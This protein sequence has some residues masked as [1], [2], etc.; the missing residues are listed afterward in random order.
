MLSYRTVGIALKCRITISA[1]RS[2]CRS[3]ISLATPWLSSPSRPPETS[4]HQTITTCLYASH[5]L[6]AI[7]VKA[8]QASLHRYDFNYSTAIS[9][10][11]LFE[12][13][14]TIQEALGFLR[15]MLKMMERDFNSYA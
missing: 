8:L 3:W 4:I 10:I 7:H 5:T 2:H 13:N 9:Q 14:D 15:L 11:S 1:L 12:H 6:D